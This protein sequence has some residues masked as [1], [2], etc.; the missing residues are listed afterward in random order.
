M[1]YNI[2]PIRDRETM[3]NEKLLR[4]RFE[5]GNTIFLRVYVI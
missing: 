5:L 3:T 4:L 2:N 1:D